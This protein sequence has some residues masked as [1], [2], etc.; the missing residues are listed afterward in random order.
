M[1]KKVEFND[2]KEILQLQKLAYQSEAFLYNDFTIPPLMETIEEI[3]QQY[4][5]HTIFKAEQNGKII[6]SI[7]GYKIDNTGY[8]GRI[9]VQPDHQNQGIGT[10][11]IQE[12]EQHF[13]TCNRFELFTGHKSFKN[14]YLYEKLGYKKCKVIEEHERLHL[15]FLEK[16]MGDL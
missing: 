4:N 1:I 13:K 14:I 16:L 3:T 11:L 7:R 5:R 12:I 2:L 9:I 6:G 10:R 8:I 15:V